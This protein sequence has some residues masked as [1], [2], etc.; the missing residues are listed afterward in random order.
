MPTKYESKRAA[1]RAAKAR[2][3]KLNRSNTIG[4]GVLLV[5]VIARL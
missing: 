5:E 1:L 2:R 3:R 4:I